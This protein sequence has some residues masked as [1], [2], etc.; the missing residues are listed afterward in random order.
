MEFLE[1]NSKIY[2]KEILKMNKLK[3]NVKYFFVL[4]ITIKGKYLIVN[5]M[6]KENCSFTNK[7][8][9]GKDIGLE[10]NFKEFISNEHIY[11]NI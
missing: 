5:L 7:N 1:I 4:K 11:Y 10:T 9:F 8:R 6:K 3:E 2:I